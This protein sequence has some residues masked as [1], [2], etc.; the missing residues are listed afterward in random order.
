MG[1]D[2][3]DAEI[4]VVVTVIS[5]VLIFFVFV[6]W[7]LR[8]PHEKERHSPKDIAVLRCAEGV[9]FYLDPD[10]ASRNLG[11]GYDKSDINQIVTMQRLPDREVDAYYEGLLPL[12]SVEIFDNPFTEEIDDV[13]FICHQ[14]IS[15]KGLWF[16]VNI[17]GE[18]FGVNVYP[19]PRRTISTRL[20]S[21]I[22]SSSSIICGWTVF[23]TAELENEDSDLGQGEAFFALS[24]SL[25]PS[26]KACASFVVACRVGCHVHRLRGILPRSAIAD[27]AGK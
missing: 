17:G 13:N 8:Q 1:M 27:L 5:L 19:A 26:L 23:S 4:I 25:V 15:R 12:L 16:N 22:M 18:T 10:S 7:A 3:E 9:Y 2:M 24:H 21:P 6:F 11:V 14:F 20:V